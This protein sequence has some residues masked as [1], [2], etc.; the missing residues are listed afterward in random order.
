MQR[1]SAA[2]EAAAEVQFGGMRTVVVRAPALSRAVLLQ[3]LQR[4]L[5]RRERRRQLGAEAAHG[6]D[7]R[8]GDAGGDQAVFDGGGAILIAEKASKKRHFS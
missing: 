1:T 4:V 2:F 3:L 7:D 6:G 5:D 8:H